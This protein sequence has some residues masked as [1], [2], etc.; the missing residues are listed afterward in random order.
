[1]TELFD[2]ATTPRIHCVDR[3]VWCSQPMR[4][5]RHEWIVCVHDYPLFNCRCTVYCFRGPRSP[6]Y[7][8]EDVFVPADGFW[9]GH[10][11]DKS[12]G[13]MPRGIRRLWER[14]RADIDRVI[15]AGIG[16]AT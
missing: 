7:L 10:D 5:G 13:G 16:G 8:P 12:D 1:M 9:S 6:S 11:G 2:R 3:V 14:N 4:L 15:A